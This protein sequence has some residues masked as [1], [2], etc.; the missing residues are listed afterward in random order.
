MATAA[1]KIQAARH[2]AVG[3]RVCCSNNPEVEF[4]EAVFLD[5]LAEGMV[6]VGKAGMVSAQEAIDVL[7]K[8]KKNPLVM[9]VVAGKPLELCRS[10]QQ[11]CL[12]WN[13]E[14]R[15]LKCVSRKH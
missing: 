14:R 13:M 4:T 10:S 6:S 15:G 9:S 5:E 7:A 2:C 12:C 8:Y 11:T 3:P 1:Q